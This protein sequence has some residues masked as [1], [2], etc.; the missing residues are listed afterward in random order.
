MIALLKRFNKFSKIPLWILSIVLAILF[1]MNNKLVDVY[2]YSYDIP[3]RYNEIPKE[4]TFKKNPP[5][6]FTVTINETGRKL[7]DI[8]FEKQLESVYI[9]INQKWQVGENHIVID[10]KDIKWKSL[11]E[12]IYHYLDKNSFT[13]YL[14]TIKEVRVPVNRDV[15]VKIK[16]GLVVITKPKFI[17]NILNINGAKSIVENIHFVEIINNKKM[18]SEAGEIKIKLPIVKKE[19]VN[20][21]KDSVEVVVYVDKKRSK[22]IDE[23]PVK[24]INQT[25]ADSIYKLNYET[26][27]IVVDGGEK[28]LSNLK[29]TDFNVFVDFSTIDFSQTTEIK[30]KITSF[31]ELSDIKSYPEKLKIIRKKIDE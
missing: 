7:F 9:D 15:E 3:I 21:D 28:I 16:E 1:W 20:F 2:N 14:D 12:N 5:K 24:I 10:K 4:L 27:S 11:G 25:S 29:N 19:G 26:I 17:D 6:K 18:I 22:V 8:H 23:I 13:V 31:K 30:P